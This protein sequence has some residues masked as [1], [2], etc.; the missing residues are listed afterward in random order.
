M[1]VDNRNNYNVLGKMGPL[2]Q[3]P[4]YRPPQKN[5]AETGGDGQVKGEGSKKETPKD[6]LTLSSNL[7]GKAVK[8]AE[9]QG[10]LN[11]Q[12]VKNLVAETSADIAALSPNSVGGCPHRVIGGDVLMYPTYA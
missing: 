7:K 4:E 9:V 2:Y 12:G 1:Q 6:S 11:L 10:K 8:K 5:T 3:R